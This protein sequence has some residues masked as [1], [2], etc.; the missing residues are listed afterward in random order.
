MSTY[1]TRSDIEDRFGVNNV[2]DWADL[3]ND[4]DATKI[5]NRITRSITWASA[6]I[7][8]HAAVS[9]YTIPLADSGGS[10]P[11]TVEH[12][13]AVLAGIWLY[14]ARGDADRDGRHRFKYDKAWA[15]RTLREMRDGTRLLDA[16]PHVRS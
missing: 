8:D 4:E 11:T 6:E 7:D 9:N 14:E 5:A 3:D 16:Q 2:A 1:C 15:Y 12:L 13:A 10:T